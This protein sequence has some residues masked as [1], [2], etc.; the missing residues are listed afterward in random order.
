M[1]TLVLALI[2]CLLAG[3]F[4]T[5]CLWNCCTKVMSDED[6]K[7]SSKE[8]DILEHWGKQQNTTQNNSIA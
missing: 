3:I 2:L 7:D 8:V 6:V 5:I 4:I 1:I